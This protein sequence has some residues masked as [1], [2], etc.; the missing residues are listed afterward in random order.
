MSEWS[1]RSVALVGC[2]RIADVHRQY[3]ATVPQAELIAVCDADPQARR[4][5]SARAAVPAYASLD[6]LLRCA[7]PHVVHIVTPPPTHA[8]LAMQALEGGAHVLVEKPMAL[9]GAAADALVAAARRRSLIVTAD[10]NRWFDPVVQRARQWLAAD[11]LGELVGV[12]IFQSAAPDPNVKTQEWK[13]RLPGGALHD[14]APHPAYLLRHFA[15]PLDTVE[16]VS[17]RDEAGQV[18]EAR[19]AARGRIACGT[20]TLSMRAR[21]AVNWVR[22]FGT[23]A[24]A[25]IN[26]N[27][28]TLVLYREHRVSKLIGKVLPNLDVAWQLLQETVRNGVEFVRGRQRFYPGMGAHL[29]AFYESITTGAPPPVSPEEARDV[30]A[31]C[32]QIFAPSAAPRLRAV[33]T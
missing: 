30:V 26:L 22:L 5:M 2:G 8:A 17:Q 3:L 29:R 7:A 4:A 9:D 18:V 14:V 28:M 13:D 33:A 1:R 10:H 23:V 24:T 25:E 19:V 20:I 6:D 11:T 15:G 32:E 21:P 31:L 12:D 16:V 27:H